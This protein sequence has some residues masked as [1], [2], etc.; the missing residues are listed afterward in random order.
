MVVVIVVVVV[1]S[2][3]K[4]FHPAR[5][6][7]TDMQNVTAGQ[8]VTDHLIQMGK[9]AQRGYGLTQGHTALKGSLLSWPPGH[10]QEPTFPCQ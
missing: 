5:V 7:S 1:V 8:D 3:T 2:L 6:V 9:Q 4:N 10:K